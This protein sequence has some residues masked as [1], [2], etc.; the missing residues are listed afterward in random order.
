M[1]NELIDTFIKGINISKK[2]KIQK[3]DGRLERI[4]QKCSYPMI[5]FDYK[6]RIQSVNRAAE[7]LFSCEKSHLLVSF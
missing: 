1:S 7:Q 2:E 6:C 3:I 4:L 5:E